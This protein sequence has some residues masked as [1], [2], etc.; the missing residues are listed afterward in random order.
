MLPIH[1]RRP[2][3]AGEIRVRGDS[4]TRGYWQNPQATH[5][6]L[7]PTT[8]DLLINQPGSSRRVPLRAG[9]PALGRSVVR[10]T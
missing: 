2:S 3:E 9:H 7:D 10:R 1:R 8:L 6:A 4:V 5:E